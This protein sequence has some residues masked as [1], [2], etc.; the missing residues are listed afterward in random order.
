LRL[1]SVPDALTTNEGAEGDIFPGVSCPGAPANGV[2]TSCNNRMFANQM[3]LAPEGFKFPKTV[4]DFGNAHSDGATGRVMRN[5]VD[6]WWDEFAGNTNNCWYGNKGPDGTAGSVTGPGA[7]DPPDN[8]PS[9]CSNTGI[10]DVGKIVIEFDCANGPDEDT[11]P[12]DCPWWQVPPKPG[13]AAASSQSARVRAASQKFDRTE[14]A[15]K[16]R[17]RVRELSSP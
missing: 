13:S 6:F 2:S 12:L 8:L 16:I 3:G 10:G 17:E 1:F 11:G 15:D 5:G 14:K 4:G 7:G 9:N